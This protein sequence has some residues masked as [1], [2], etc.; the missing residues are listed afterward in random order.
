MACVLSCMTMAG[1]A[2]HDANADVDAE[3][4]A[5]DA[6]LTEEG[7]AAECCLGGSS[8]F[9]VS[10]I[11]HRHDAASETRTIEHDMNNGNN[12]V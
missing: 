12:N 7:S 9:A 3:P 11:T 5:D 2:A 4:D 10:H 1:A 8:I 6:E